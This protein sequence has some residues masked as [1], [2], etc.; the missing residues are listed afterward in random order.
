MQY[1]VKQG[2]LYHDAFEYTDGDVVE[3]SDAAAPQLIAVGVVVFLEAE[4]EPPPVEV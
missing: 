2:P 3:L 4:T 1:A